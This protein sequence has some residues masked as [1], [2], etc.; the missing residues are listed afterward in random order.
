MVVKKFDRIRKSNWYLLVALFV[1][2]CSY[3]LQAD[4]QIHDAFVRGLP[5]GQSV[6][7]AF[8]RLR[9]GAATPA[10]VVAASTD[11]AAK[12]EIH[13]HVH[14]EGMMRME[15]VERLAVPAHDEVL[16][17][18][19]GFHLMLIDLHKPLKEG[20]MVQVTLH[21]EGGEAV[22]ATLPVRSVLNEHKHH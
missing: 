10:I 7:A 6:T 3:K 9:N 15:K 8:M 21:M 1:T 5:P 17:K 16:L 18:P 2:L 19:G 11:S 20:D 4:V 13:G 14:N 22:S 12:A